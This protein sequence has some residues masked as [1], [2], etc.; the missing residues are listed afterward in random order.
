MDDLS[1]ISFRL[2]L[3][4]A[5]MI[6]SKTTLSATP[7][8][9]R[10]LL[11]VLIACFPFATRNAIAQVDRVFPFTGNPVVGKI[12]EIRPQGV[13]IEVSGT[14]QTIAIDKIRRVMFEDEP[15]FLTRGRDFV[16]DGDF[17][18]AMEMLGKVDFAEIKRDAIKADAMYYLARSESALALIGRGNIAEA[19]RKMNAF[20]TANRQSLHFYPAAK[21]LGDLAVASGN[22]EQAL[23]YYAALAQAPAAEMKIE[24]EYLSGNALLRQGKLPEAEASFAKVGGATVDS[25][26]GVRLKSLAKAGQAVVLA[27]QGNAQQALSLVSSLIGELAPVD[28]QLGARIYNAQG[29][30]LEALND[31]EGAV[32]AYLHT[33]LMF[34][35][36]ADAHAEALLRLV[37]LWP[38]VGHPERAAQ[39]RQELQQRYPGWLK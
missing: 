23:R 36:Q 22:H 8:L 14:P 16:L 28:S 12:T 37:E 29:A 15:N 35:G 3:V 4:S 20:A 39:A 24:A 38:Q 27:K 10:F 26:E 2:Q 18:Q 17:E 34:S 25:A 19:T 5:P 6:T 30:C 1:V 7:M 31:R 21:V 11:P 9:S 33:H 32:L 13:V